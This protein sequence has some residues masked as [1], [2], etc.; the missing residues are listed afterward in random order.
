[1]QVFEALL[2]DSGFAECRKPVQVNVT[3][4]H[5]P[6]FS[7]VDMTIQ[8]GAKASEEIP[9]MTAKRIKGSVAIAA[10]VVA[11]ALVG[12]LGPRNA[13]GSSED[14]SRVT[15]AVDLTMP[16]DTVQMYPKAESSHGLKMDDLNINYYEFDD[17]EALEKEYQGVS[18]AEFLRAVFARAVKGREA[19][20]DNEKWLAIMDYFS[21]SM[22]HPQVEQ[23]T[24]RDGTMVTDPMILM[25][26]HE[27]RC[28]HQARVIVDLA[29]ANHYEARL[30]Q[31]AAHLVAEV[32]WDG[33]WHWIDA[34]AGIPVDS[35]RS[36]FAELPSVETL[37]RTPYVLDS[38]AARNWE[39][40]D[41][42]RRTVDGKMAPADI[43]YGSQL[44]TSATYFGKQIFSGI[45]GGRN[46]SIEGI[47]YYYKKGTPAQWAADRFWGWNDL[48]T[49]VQPIPTVPIAYF[50][51]PLTISGPPAV[52]T[53]GGHGVVPVRWT[54]GGR[55]VCDPDR[56]R[57]CHLTFDNLGYE[58]R[59]SSATRGWDYDYRDYNFM[60]NRGKGDVLVTRDVRKIDSE[61]YGIDLP[62]KDLS[63][64]FIEVVPVPLDP[65]HATDFRWPSN[66]LDVQVMRSDGDR[67]AGGTQ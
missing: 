17:V 8:T 51:L 58:V 15:A 46:A 55:T 48:R 28:G 5:F 11:L 38:F 21:R 3:A 25:L 16:N 36:R 9:P 60:P 45:Y 18:R 1:V 56:V 59:V 27:G 49:E 52:Y 39:W 23:P 43:W 44:T 35:L 4:V 65:A 62:V 66:E 47:T 22:R 57:K 6:K 29:L 13:V 33:K 12:Y 37:A 10:S 2:Y 14:N 30:I 32:K 24:N 7:T 31:L 42:S 67:A 63:E 64:V 61:T 41:Y 54:A 50:L 34:D 19:S 20:G 26:L 53:E 40:G